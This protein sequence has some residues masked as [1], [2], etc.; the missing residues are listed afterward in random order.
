M[1]LMCNCGAANPCHG[2]ALVELIRESN[3]KAW[4][5]MIKTMPGKEVTFFFFPLFSG[6]SERP[7]GIRVHIEALGGQCLD[8]AWSVVMSTMS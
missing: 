8:W 6:P 2:Y 5:D 1:T 3:D 7:D 4:V